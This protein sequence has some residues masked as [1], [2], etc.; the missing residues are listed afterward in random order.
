MLDRGIVPPL[1]GV[2]W[3]GTGYGSDGTVWGGEFFHIADGTVKRIAHLRRFPLPGG[4][5]AAREPRRSALGLLSK[6]YDDP[7]KY[8]PAG[9][10]SIEESDI[11]KQMLASRLN[12]PLTSSAG[13]L[14]DAVAS[15]LDLY[16]TIE[17]EGQAAMALEHAIGGIETEESY[18]VEM[19][20]IAGE[21]V[22]IDWAPLVK[23]V[24]MDAAEGISNG[25]ISAK[26]HNTLAVGIAAVAQR[27]GEKKV[28]LSGGCFQN[29]YLLGRVSNMLENLGYEPVIHRSLPP[30]DG[31]IA[32]G[33]VMAA[34]F[35]ESK[36]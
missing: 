14:F 2:S 3:D 16:Q 7:V 24:I 20:Q 28:V 25:I 26:F 4:D 35:S 32:P 15:I 13:R 34:L 36:K 30:N 10:F 27:V 18:S 1:L 6:L 31:G 21:P 8:L 29:I 11:I 22:I 9:T 17:F 5:S 33:Q 19:I 23:G 12:S